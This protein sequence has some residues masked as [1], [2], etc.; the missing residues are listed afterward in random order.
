M[1]GDIQQLFVDTKI[2]FEKSSIKKFAENNKLSWHY[3]VS[4]THLTTNNNVIVGFNW[5]ATDNYSYKPQAEM[6]TENFKQLYDKQDLGSLQRIYEPLKKCFPY[7]DIDN[8][9]QTNFC[10][11]RSKKES[12]ITSADLDLSTPLFQKLLVIIKPK[13]I[14]GF[15]NKLRDY[16]LNNKLCSSV[17]TFNIPSNKKT[18]FVA[19]GIYRLNRQDIPILFLPHPNSRFTTEA[20]QTAWSSMVLGL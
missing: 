12:Q 13:R 4:S 6:P 14:I 17:E 2:A 11:F 15:S 1:T 9:V 18:L 7:E 20:R 3:S 5:G 19:K 16:F 8:C 10:F